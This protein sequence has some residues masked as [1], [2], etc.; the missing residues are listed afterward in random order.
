MLIALLSTLW[1]LSRAVARIFDWRWSTCE[2]S[3]HHSSVA[4]SVTELWLWSVGEV[5]A[6]VPIELWQGSGGAAPGIFFGKFYFLECIFTIEFNFYKDDWTSCSALVSLGQESIYYLVYLHY[7]YLLYWSFNNLQWRTKTW[8]VISYSLYL[9]LIGYWLMVEW[10]VLC[11]R[12]TVQTTVTTDY[13]FL[14]R[15][16]CLHFTY[17]Y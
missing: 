7:I 1:A 13:W 6:S 15:P 11:D 5:S 4:R 9:R 17:F 2:R 12:S 8:H 3:E 14:T 16:H 10:S